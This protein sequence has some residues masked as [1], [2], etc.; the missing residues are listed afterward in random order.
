MQ[1]NY[2][3]Q[4]ILPDYTGYSKISFGKFYDYFVHVALGSRKDMFI[5]QGFVFGFLPRAYY[6]QDLQNSL[7][8]DNANLEEASAVEI[9]ESLA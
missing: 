2:A 9:Y 4:R 7:R 3:I 8:S 5:Y 6:L 1:G